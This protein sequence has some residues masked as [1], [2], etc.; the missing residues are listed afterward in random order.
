MLSVLK[1]EILNI[2]LQ[3]TL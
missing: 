2:T 1:A 3:V